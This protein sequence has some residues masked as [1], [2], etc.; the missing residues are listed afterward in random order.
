MEAS[1][2]ELYKEPLPSELE[3]EIEDAA[4]EIGEGPARLRVDVWPEES[5]RLRSKVS[6]SSLPERPPPILVP[7]CVPGGLGPHKWADRTLL[8]ALAESVAPGIPLICDLDGYVL[9]AA[10]AAIFVDFGQGRLVTPPLDGRIL[11]GTARARI[12]AGEHLPPIGPMPS[13]RPVH[14]TEL[15]SASALY[16]SNA[17]TPLTA[18]TLQLRSR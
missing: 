13:E 16:I 10:H 5:G 15:E 1:L 14:L 3:A 8:D 12:I 9:E 2:N 4:L 18:A 6:H 11:P 7:V 17:L